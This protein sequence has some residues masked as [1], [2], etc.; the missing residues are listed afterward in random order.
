MTWRPDVPQ[1]LLPARFE[2]AA[3]VIICGC[4]AVTAALGL[5]FA[6]RT[7]AAPS[8]TRSSESSRVARTSGPA[9]RVRGGC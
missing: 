2:A 9:D 3:I 6:H 5:M 4:A 7:T 8:T 1:R